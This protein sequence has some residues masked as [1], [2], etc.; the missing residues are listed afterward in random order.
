MYGKRSLII[1]G[2]RGIGA[3]VKEVFTSR[4]DD[5][6]TASRTNSADPKHFFI[7]L[8][9]HINLDRN[10]DFNYL[11]FAHRYRGTDWDDD[12]DITVIG[13]D[14]TVEGENV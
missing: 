10:I 4:G 1:G 13:I 8:P 11:V 12:F 14:E 3:V 9:D 2:T 6:S 5:V 7:N